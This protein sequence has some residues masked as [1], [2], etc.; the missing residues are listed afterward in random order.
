MLIF[1]K[2]SFS[3]LPQKHVMGLT[4]FLFYTHTNMQ[5]HTYTH[6]CIYRVYLAFRQAH[7]DLVVLLYAHGNLYFSPSCIKNTT[8]FQSD[9]KWPQ[10]NHLASF[11]MVKSKSLMHTLCLIK[12]LFSHFKHVLVNDPTSS[13]ATNESNFRHLQT[14]GCY[15]VDAF[16][17]FKKEHLRQFF[18][19]F[20]QNKYSETWS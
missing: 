1:K 2:R 8:C 16:S 19:S 13:F 12:N 11:T 20:W 14:F 5:T 17:E 18:K 4:W 15:L 9:Q 10:N 3:R 6:F 7:L